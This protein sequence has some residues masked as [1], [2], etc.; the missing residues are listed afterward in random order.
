[1]NLRR[2]RAI[3]RKEFLHII[4]D[5]RSL[6]ISLTLPL[7]IL[8]LFGYALSLDVNRILTVVDDRDRSP[9]SRALI[10]R[11]VSSGYFT[12][13]G[14]VGGTGQVSG[15]RQ[16]DQLIN[17]GR[18]MVAIVVPE[19]FAKQIARGQEAE[20]QLLIDGSD[21]NT[22]SI[23]RGYA[24]NIVRQF[25]LE[26]REQAQNLRGLPKMKQPVDLRARIVY[27]DDLR[28]RNY[29]VPGL[30]AVILM[31]IASM[32]TS[33]TVARE[34]ETGTMEQL[35][36]TPIRPIEL[37][38]GKLTA[39]FAVGMVDM[40]VCLVAAVFVFDVPLKGSLLELIAISMLFLFGVLCWG[41]MLSTVAK[42]QAMAYQMGMLTSFLPA[43][44]L[45]G[46]IYS[47]ENMPWLIQSISYLVPARYFITILK[48][49]FLKGVALRVMWVEVLFLAL[50][51]LLVFIRTMRKM[52]L[53]VA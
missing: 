2:Y 5:P 4:R 24:E 43:F 32:L 22:A 12:V 39:F 6:S 52:R 10:E 34:W 25:A 28:S 31:I 21:S 35:V 53:K 19:S 11:F 16:I 46:F 14:Q 18:A 15:T 50:Y 26:Q 23:A 3:A 44:L 45:S 27:N 47:T 13:I 36:S 8:L 42:N 38:L 48:G 37:L 17:S 51:A 30:I 41:I 29:I 1:M 33:L 49:I 9:E 20:V 40:L 7:V